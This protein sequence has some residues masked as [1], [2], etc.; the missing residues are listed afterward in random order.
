MDEHVYCATCG[1][2]FGLP[3]ALAG[4]RRTDRANF[5]CPNGHA[6]YFV[7]RTKHEARAKRLER[8]AQALRR[9]LDAALARAEDLADAVRECPLPGCRYRSRV[10]VPLDPVRAGRAT[11]GVRRDLFEHMLR[12]H[13]GGGREPRRLPAGGGA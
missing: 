11:E 13:A 5:Y 8:R 12:D 4:Q 3:A 9:R 1:V 6:N 10:G 2:Q 7:G